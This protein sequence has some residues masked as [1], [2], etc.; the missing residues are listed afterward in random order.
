MSERIISRNENG[1]GWIIFNNMEKRNAVS[2]AMAKRVAEI[3]KEF[4]ENEEEYF[5]EEYDTDSEEGE[6]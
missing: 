1:I 4:E 2:L 6:K 3:I 5:S